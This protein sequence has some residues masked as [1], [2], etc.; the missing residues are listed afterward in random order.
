MRKAVECSL[1]ARES[2]AGFLG[3]KEVGKHPGCC[4]VLR[5]SETTV[6]AQGLELPGS[7][8][9]C[10]TCHKVSCQPLRVSR[11]ER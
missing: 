10:T 8:M 4:S 7:E 2:N 1:G 6:R 11:G 5:P 9:D 3:V